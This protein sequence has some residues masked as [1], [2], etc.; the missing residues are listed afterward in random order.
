MKNESESSSGSLESVI[1]DRGQLEVEKVKQIPIE[2]ALTK[3]T[4][5][6]PFGE[7]SDKHTGDSSQSND[8]SDSSDDRNNRNRTIG[9]L[10]TWW[11]RWSFRGLPMLLLGI[12]LGSFYERHVGVSKGAAADARAEARCGPTTTDYIVKTTHSLHSYH[13]HSHQ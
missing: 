12:L 6:K 9:S 2:R 7:A 8:A 1:L 11:K 5:D 4:V 13:C 10:L 3:A